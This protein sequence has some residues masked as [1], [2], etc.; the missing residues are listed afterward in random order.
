MATHPARCIVARRIP[1]R[2]CLSS[3]YAPNS[4]IR[5]SRISI[6]LLRSA[7]GSARLPIVAISYRACNFNVLAC[8]PAR[9]AVAAGERLPIMITLK[10]ARIDSK[11][12]VSACRRASKALPMPTLRSDEVL[13]VSDMSNLSRTSHLPVIH[14]DSAANGRT[15]AE[16]EGLETAQRSAKFR[17]DSDCC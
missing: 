5:R 1:K 17:S 2:Y 7:C 6:K 8:D 11:C 12:L 15:R 10:S 14:A 4:S 16:E 3:V 13:P 9:D